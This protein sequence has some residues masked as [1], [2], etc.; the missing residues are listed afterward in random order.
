MKIRPKRPR[1]AK[2]KNK[3]QKRLYLKGQRKGN[4]KQLLKKGI[5]KKKIHQQEEENYMQIFL[6]NLE[7]EKEDF[8]NPRK[9]NK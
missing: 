9:E 6:R 2:V 5:N 4:S 1:K 8:L 7:I 3:D